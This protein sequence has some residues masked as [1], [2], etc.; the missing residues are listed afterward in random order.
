MSPNKKIRKLE[1]DI[2]TRKARVSGRQLL[3][4]NIAAFTLVGL[5]FAYG[6]KGRG[7]G[8]AFYLQ[9]AR[10]LA[11]VVPFDPEDL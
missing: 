3:L 5:A 11:N 1:A 9:L 2:A 6:V 8:V 4:M 7:P 10:Q